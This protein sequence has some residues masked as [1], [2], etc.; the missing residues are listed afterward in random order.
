MVAGRADLAPAYELIFRRLKAA[1]CDWTYHFPRLN[2]VD[3]RPLRDQL[4]EEKADF[5]DYDPSAA[6]AKEHERQEHDE[7]VG[8]MREQLDDA[9]RESVE[10]AQDGPPPKTV[11]VYQRVFGHFP[12]GWPPVVEE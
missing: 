4:E 8:K 2:L 12:E 11:E 5:T 3:L 6:F 9:Y 1:G 10:R 7:E